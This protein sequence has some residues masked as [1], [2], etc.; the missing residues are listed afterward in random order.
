MKPQPELL[1][2]TLLA[3]EQQTEP[4]ARVRDVLFYSGTPILRY[5][6]WN[7]EEYL[8]SF[9]TDPKDVRL[10][11]LNAGAPVFKDHVPSVDSTIG[12]TSNARITNGKAYATLEFSAREDLD[13]FWQDVQA[14]IIRAVS[15]GV[16]MDSL[17][18]ITPKKKGA[19]KHLM[20][21]GWEP[22]EI[23]V[24]P[25][26]ADPK[27]KFLAAQ[28]M[29][30]QHFARQ[31]QQSPIPFP[32]VG[33]ELLTQQPAQSQQEPSVHRSDARVKLALALNLNQ[34]ERNWKG[35]KA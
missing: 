25:L 8:L 22:F 28:F 16:A 10:N 17:E 14:G 23:S 4:E 6:M 15:M 30:E 29:S 3:P 31:A 7:D 33:A 24:V 18:D 21:R 35:A 19:M 26:G 32:L 34:R 20:A 5:D 9:S 1:T 2:A 12:K 27:A 11:R 13:G